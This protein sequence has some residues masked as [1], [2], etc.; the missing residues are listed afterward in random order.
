MN[1]KKKKII[2]HNF[3]FPDF[4]SIEDAVQQTFSIVAEFCNLIQ[5]LGKFLQALDTINAI[6]NDQQLETNDAIRGVQ[7]W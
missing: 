3:L 1:S 7:K 6:L 5:I 4:S 2:S